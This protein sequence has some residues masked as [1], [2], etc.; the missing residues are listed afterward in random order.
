ML[1][2]NRFI[3]HGLILAIVLLAV[4]FFSN[5][6]LEMEANNAIEDQQGV[7]IDPDKTVGV[8]EVIHFENSMFTPY[9]QAG[10]SSAIDDVNYWVKLSLSDFS[11]EDRDYFLE[12]T[13][14]HLSEVDFYQ[15]SADGQ[16]VKQVETGRNRPFDSREVDYRTF[17]F[18]LDPSHLEGTV[19]FKIHTESYLQ[20]TTKL[21][22][23]DQLA[24]HI[25][26]S[27]MGLGVFYGALAIM[28]VY[29]AFLAYSLKD[30][31]YLYYILF[32]G[33]FTVL[34]LIWDGYSYQ[35]LWRDASWWDTV[36][37]PFF[38][39]MTGYWLMAFNWSFFDVKRRPRMARFFMAY[40]V[41]G[42]LAM[43]TSLFLP[44]RM[45]LYIS[46]FYVI[47][48]LV[49]SITS[50]VVSKPRKRSHFMYISA[51]SVFFYMSLLSTLG[52]FNLIPYSILAV[53]G[54]KIGV[55]ILIV[56]FSL[57]LSDK[58]KES[59]YLRIVEEE[60]GNLLRELHVVSKESTS[61]QDLDHLY[62][63]MLKGYQSIAPFDGM[64]LCVENWD[65]TF[66][67]IHGKTVHAYAVM[68]DVQ[69]HYG[70]LET[71]CVI[72]A[73]DVFRKQFA[74]DPEVHALL[75]P[76]E[77]R[78]QKLG[79]IVLYGSNKRPFQFQGSHDL[80][81]DYTYQIAL[82]IENITLLQQLKYEAEHDSLSKLLNR[83]TFFDRAHDQY[84]KMVDQVSIIMMDIDH[85]KSINDRF[86]HVVG[87][88][89]IQLVSR[90]VR[91]LVPKD[92]LIGRYGG[93][94]FIVALFDYSH[95]EVIAL[96]ESVRGAIEAY[97]LD[98][99]GV[100]AFGVTLSA[101]VHTTKDRNL[102]LVQI[103][104]Q[105]DDKLYQAKHTGRNQVLA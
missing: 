50:V 21:W 27:T 88:Q 56:F 95:E 69:A 4:A 6:V 77:S 93:E 46:L 45:A 90:K 36:A 72:P 10:V 23:S 98:I 80:V 34:Q 92:A 81:L 78:T 28:I 33:S 68:E 25:A 20:V 16:V 11:F 51:W 44:M 5:S 48:A 65:Q 47:C 75:V 26:M 30:V 32:V 66:R 7:W 19:L 101:G 49:F 86:G 97:G 29:N 104:D 37:N 55:V 3:R 59:E 79:F 18:Q 41:T 84:D 63:H 67:Y 8:T 103:I 35:F 94:E 14:P 82:T 87:D 102:T 58:I 17:V 13:K 22:T 15:V 57:A 42:A 62:G 1:D 89:V 105:A 76:I 73:P 71:A 99:E 70:S 60:K 52:G 96:A 38:I 91:S 85:F 31:K 61:L 74:I 64:I 39:G 9:G 54:V 2:R 53:H 12:L 43:V 40:F 24:V 83:R 100:E